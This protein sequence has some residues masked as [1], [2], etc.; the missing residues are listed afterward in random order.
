VQ[1]TFNKTGE[2]RDWI[3]VERGDGTQTRWRWP[4]GGP[5][6]DLIHYVVET[7][8]GLRAAFWGLVDEGLMGKTGL[9]GHDA[10]QLVQAECIVGAVTQAVALTPEVSDA[11]CLARMREFC[12]KA[13]VEP[14]TLDEPTIARLRGAVSEAI[15][16]WRALAPRES[17]VLEY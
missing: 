1:I 10:T 14:P 3:Y 7:E 2:R 5:P 11:E 17:L 4:A 6:H 8:L 16:R 13:E 12:L 9:A 15:E